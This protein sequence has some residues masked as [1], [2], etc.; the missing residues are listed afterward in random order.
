MLFNSKD[1]FFL[2]RS[3][4]HKITY[5]GNLATT[6]GE[7]HGTPLNPRTVIG[8]TRQYTLSPQRGGKFNP[9]SDLS[10]SGN[11]DRLNHKYRAMRCR[12]CFVPFRCHSGSTAGEAMKRRV[13]PDKIAA[14]LG[15]PR[16]WYARTPVTQRPCSRCETESITVP[17][18]GGLCQE[19]RQEIPEPLLDPFPDD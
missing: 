6:E 9:A 12:P 15:T 18:P 11:A 5:P 16:G 2:C 1:Y 19:C 17:S 3:V 13:S 7:S 10:G 8:D 14:A 4:G